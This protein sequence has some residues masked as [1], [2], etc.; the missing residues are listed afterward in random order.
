MKR[1]IRIIGLFFLFLFFGS[2]ATK[3]AYADN[4]TIT[5]SVKNSSN[6]AV[7]DAT[8][9]IYNT[10]TTNDVVSPVT[11]DQSGNYIFSSVPQGTYDIE[12]T[13]PL[14]SNFLL[15]YIQIKKYHQTQL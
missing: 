9:D 3:F 7:S 5:G 4:A 2:F 10:G 12:V 14:G 8:V 6:I 13:P 15:Y 11:T 1:S